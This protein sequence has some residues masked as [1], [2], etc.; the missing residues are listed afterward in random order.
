MEYLIGLLIEIKSL[1]NQLENFIRV[2]VS[3]KYPKNTFKIVVSSTTK[4]RQIGPTSLLPKSQP[5]KVG[6]TGS[7]RGFE[8][9]QF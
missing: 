9:Q 2:T 8:I 4:V 1:S 6:Q 5:P 3:P 7:P